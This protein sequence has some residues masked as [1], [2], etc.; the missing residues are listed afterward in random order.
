MYWAEL[1][2]KSMGFNAFEKP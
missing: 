1:L 2:L